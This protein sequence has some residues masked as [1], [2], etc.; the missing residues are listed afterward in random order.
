MTT[1]DTYERSNSRHPKRSCRAQGGGP[2][3]ARHR[4]ERWLTTH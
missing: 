2:F 1:R 3:G 4:V